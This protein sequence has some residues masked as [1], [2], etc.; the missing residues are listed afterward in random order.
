M[1]C[2]PRSRRAMLCASLV[3]A[4]LASSAAH[5]APPKPRGFQFGVIGHALQASQDEAALKRAIAE[6]TQANPAFIVATGIK[7]GSEPCSDRLYA[8]RRALLDESAQ[9]MI[10]S[11]AGSDWSGCLNSAGRSN[12][13]ERLNRLRELFYG[14]GESLG[15]RRIPLTRLSSTA[16]FRSY[17]EN[18]HWEYGKV[19][20]A[21]VNLPA[22]NNHYRPEAGRNSEYE[23]RLVANRA[24]LHRLFTLA[25]RQKMQGLVLFS[26]GDVGLQADEGF[27]LLPSF[28]SR[29]D[30]FAEPRRQIKAMAEKFKG[31]VLLIDAQNSAAAATTGSEPAIQWRDNVGH[32]SLGAEWA[33]VRVAPG[34]ATLFSIKGGGADAPQ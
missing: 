27:S 15:A 17:A 22:N 14:D 9:P 1:M 16:K 28:Q 32:L 23:D 18:A 13:I 19:L 29:Q 7:A 5:A 34:A 26:D 33:E 21:T 8:Q 30:G 31:K 3:L 11:L 25:T 6:A 10:V 24:W 20:F 2:T 4:A 12:A